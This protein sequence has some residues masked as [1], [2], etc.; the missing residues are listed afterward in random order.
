MKIDKTKYYF[1]KEAAQLP[2]RFF[3]ELLIHPSGDMAGEAFK[4]EKWQKEIFA[5]AFGW[6]HRS[7]KRRKHRMNYLEVPKGNGKSMILSGLAL[8]M[9]SLGG[10]TGGEV[11][12][13][14]GDREQARIVFDTCRQMI[15][16]N[17]KLAD[18]FNVWKYSIEHKKSGSVLKVLSADS[19]TKHGYRPYCI[20]FDELHVQPNSDLYDT[21]TRGLIKIKN[22]V[23]WMITT[24]GVIE[25]FAEKIHNR[26]L[27]IKNGIIKDDSWLPIIYAAD[28]DD[29]PFSVKTWKK[30][31]PGYGTIIDPFD[32]KILAKEAE[33]LPSS[34]YAFLRLHLNIW[35]GA[36]EAWI[37]PHVF[38]KC[39][40]GAVDLEHHEQNQTRAY[41]GLDI[42]STD[43]LSAFSMIFRNDDT[44]VFDWVCYFWIPEEKVQEEVKK[45]NTSYLQWVD[46]G[47]IFTTPGNVQDK[48]QILK[49]INLQAEKYNIQCVG[50][51]TSYHRAV[52]GNWSDQSGIEFNPFR[53][54]APTFTVPTKEMEKLIK[55]QSLNYA[56][57]PVLRWQISNTEVFRDSNDNIKPM[58]GMGKGRNAGRR[59]KKIDG[60]VAGIM[61]L[62]EYINAEGM[63][64]NNLP[65]D[66]KFTII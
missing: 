49:F 1:D 26:A 3:E 58:K 40:L 53:Q 39:N 42:A 28:K 38:E 60:V 16:E 44:G 22:S 31:N 19:Y 20:I 14:A 35:T 54:N 37:A 51:D 52:I 34:Y 18:K 43:D 29:K 66:Y 36:V 62:G 32:F 5:P 56:G 30:A 65:S 55:T 33:S 11:Y 59:H 41:C 6:K 8:F 46:E 50:V 25:T 57:N 21:L 4:L 63:E 9:L 47:Y 15:I 17:P 7:N 12:C 10:I 13:C 45:G 64:D 23:C 27:K 2:I 24:A 48:D 61:A